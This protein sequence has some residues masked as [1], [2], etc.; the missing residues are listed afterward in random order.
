MI[1][2]LS[3]EFWLCSALA[4]SAGTLFGASWA[5]RKRDRQLFE[6]YR[7]RAAQNRAGPTTPVLQLSTQGATGHADDYR[8][9][10]GPAGAAPPQAPRRARRG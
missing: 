2:F 6:L 4:F 8:A 1:L 9:G 7:D 10:N 5:A 3:W